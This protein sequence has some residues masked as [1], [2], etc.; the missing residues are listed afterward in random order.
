M[1]APQAMKMPEKVLEPLR[2]LYDTI[3]TMFSDRTYSLREMI[4]MMCREGEELK[5]LHLSASLDLA[6]LGQVAEAAPV[7]KVGAG[8]VR[9]ASPSRKRSRQRNC[10]VR[11]ALC[12]L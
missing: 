9:L 2:E 10:Y 8:Y 3:E 7:R 5:E 4:Q 1:G 6:F 12:R 11:A